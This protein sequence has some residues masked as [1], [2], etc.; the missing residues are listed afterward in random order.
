MGVL[1]PLAMPL[2]AAELLSICVNAG[3]PATTCNCIAALDACI[4]R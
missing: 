2:T 3:V 1:Q 4:C